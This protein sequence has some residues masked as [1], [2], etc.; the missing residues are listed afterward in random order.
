MKPIAVHPREADSMHALEPL[1]TAPVHRRRGGERM[2]RELLAE[3]GEAVRV[4][5]DVASA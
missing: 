5:A 4:C 1:L 2:L 3:G